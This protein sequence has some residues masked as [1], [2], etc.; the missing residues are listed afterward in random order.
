MKLA[1]LIIAILFLAGG[2]GNFFIN[3]K[4]SP[5]LRKGNW[6]KYF[7]YLLIISIVLVSIIMDRRVFTALFILINTVGLLEMMTISKKT[8]PS[9]YNKKF[10]YTSFFIFGIILTFFSAFI[11]LPKEIIVF[12]YTVVLVFDGACQVTGQLLGKNKIAPVISPNKTREGFI[13]GSLIAVITAVLIRNL[14]GFSMGAACLSGL[15]ICLSS[16]T[17]DLLASL[18]KR[19]FGAKNFSHV[20]PGQGGMFDRFD[21]FMASGAILGFLGIPYLYQHGF[22]KDVL[23]YCLITVLFYGVLMT[24]EFIYV[25]FRIKPE[26]T[27]IVSHF[28]AGTTALLFLTGFSVF[29]YVLVMCLHFALFLYITAGKGFLASHHQVQRKTK[30][31]T[32]FF[33]GIFLT[34]FASVLLSKQYLLVIPIL[35]LTISDPVAALV[36]IN[37][38]SGHWPSLLSSRKSR[39]TY[40]GS[41]AF[42]ISSVLILLTLLPIYYDF[43]LQNLILVSL[44]TGCMATMAET[45]SSN[46]TDNITVPVVIVSNLLIMDCLVR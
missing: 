22:D 9:S 31:S 32:I 25:S 34:Y 24:G 7:F 29:W 16:F 18:F 40:A 15:V 35:I 6:K 5:D 8:D 17:G 12:T 33:G 45:I 1:L 39:K 28:L 4:L 36:G 30:G 19:K 44:I 21:S 2:A 13:Y 43:T 46:G 37:I 38:Q 42:L 11:Q 10:L 27:R 3:R 14:A 20:L 23:L 41:L 26:Y